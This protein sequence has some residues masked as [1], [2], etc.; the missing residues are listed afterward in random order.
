MSIKNLAAVAAT[1]VLLMFS[2]I[3]SAV[4]LKL[5]RYG[6]AG[7]EKPGLIDSQ[8]RIR[9]LSSHIDDIGP[10]TLSD[11]ALEQIAQIPLAELPLVQGNPRIGVP[12]T[13]TGKIIAIGF[14][15]VNHAAE[16]AVELPSEP[17]VFMKATS[18]LTGPFDNVI[19]AP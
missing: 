15:Y 12:V 16:M 7:E 4:E 17:L 13:G 18:A 10:A 14:N 3:L 9:D 19:P 11:A 6:P 1:S 8:G 5:L 2:G